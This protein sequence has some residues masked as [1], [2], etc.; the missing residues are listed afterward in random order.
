MAPTHRKRK[1]SPHGP[2]IEPFLRDP[3]E[4]HLTEALERSE[5]LEEVLG[6]A[7]KSALDSRK[8]WRIRNL[9]GVVTVL[10]RELEG[11]APRAM[12]GSHD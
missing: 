9:I 11:I 3:D 5:E 10:R 7:F 8:A 4:S 12:G 6:E 2:R 1:T